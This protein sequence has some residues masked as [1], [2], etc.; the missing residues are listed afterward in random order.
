MEFTKDPGFWVFLTALVGVVRWLLKVTFVYLARSQEK[1][2]KLENDNNVNNARLMTS[3]EMLKMDNTVKLVGILKQTMDE[4]K[5]VLTE[6]SE[7]LSGFRASFDLLQTVESEA[8]NMMMELKTQYASFNKE[9]A[10]FNLIGDNLMG[11]MKAIET[12]ILELKKGSGNVY[13]TSKK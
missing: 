7:I 9:V 2:A 4:I 11:R 13:V 10:R 3:V 5:P 12:E 6:H 8:T 1:K